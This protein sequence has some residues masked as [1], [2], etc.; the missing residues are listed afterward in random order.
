MKSDIVNAFSI[1]FEDWYQGLEIIDMKNWHNY[2]SRIERNCNGCLEILAKYNVKA[3]FFVLG[4]LAENYPKLIRDIASA[5]HEVGSHGYSHTQIF[6]LTP[7]KF[8]Q[9]LIRTNDSIA[10]ACGKKPIGFRAPIFSVLAA[11]HWSFDLLSENGFIYDSSINP[12]LN[13]RYGYIR[14]DRF[15]H[16][17]ITNSGARI[18]EIPVTSA[19]IFGLNFPVG[20]GAYFRFWPYFFTRW[21]FNKVNKNG[22]PGV[23]Y[24]HPWEIDPEQPRINLPFRLSATHYHRLD[25]TKSLLESL[26]SD[27]KFSTMASVFGIEY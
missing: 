3:T 2:E 13:Y 19:R 6:R 9:E 18:I 15:K 23:F 21:A 8:N 5:G 12:T 16:E 25:S 4:Y 24:M 17:I 11:S 14:A 20:G 27:F 26:L 22:K 1:D 10:A 7:E